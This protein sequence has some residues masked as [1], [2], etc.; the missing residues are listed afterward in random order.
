MASNTLPLAVVLL[1]VF[2]PQ[3]INRLPLVSRMYLQ[4]QSLADVGMSSLQR[5]GG[6]MLLPGLADGAGDNGEVVAGGEIVAGGIGVDCVLWEW[7]CAWRAL[8]SG[9]CATNSC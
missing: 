4:S 2:L 9:D 8:T 1:L 3:E 5:I 6:S 7:R